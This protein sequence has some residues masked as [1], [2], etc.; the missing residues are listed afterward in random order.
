MP[1]DV[2]LSIFVSVGSAPDHLVG[3]GQIASF[4]GNPPQDLSGP[5]LELAERS[6]QDAIRDTLTRRGNIVSFDVK[7][8][9]IGRN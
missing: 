3:R 1:R 5:G 8:A 7:N 4:H 6:A 2:P 9:K